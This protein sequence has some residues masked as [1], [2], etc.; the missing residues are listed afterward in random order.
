MKIKNLLLT[1]A[2]AAVV[3]FSCQDPVR[4]PRPDNGSDQGGQDKPVTLEH[5]GTVEDPYSVADA[6][7]FTKAL[8]SDVQSE[9]DVYIKGVVTS[10]KEAFGSFGNVTLYIGD[11]AT[12]TETFYV[13]RV[14]GLGNKKCTD[15]NAVKEGDE[16]VVCGKV[17]NFKGNTPETV[18]GSAF[19]YSINGKSEPVDNPVAGEAKGT[20]TEADPFNVA[21]AIAKCQEAGTTATTEVYYVTGKV[22]AVDESGAV[23]YGNITL[24]LVDEGSTAVFK[25]YRIKSVG[26]AAFTSEGNVQVGDVVV[27]KGQLVNYSNNTPE[28]AQNTGE[29]VSVNGQSPVAKPGISVKAETSINYDILEAEV[30][31]TVNNPVAGQNVTIADVK[32]GGF[33]TVTLEAAAVKVVFA[34]ENTTENAKVVSFTLKYQGASDVT[35]TVTQKV[36]PTG[37]QPSFES[38]L[39]YIKGTNSYDDGKAT[40][41]ETAD[42]VVYKLGTSKAA[43]DCKFTVP[44]GVT[45]IG[46]YAVAWKGLSGIKLTVGDKEVTVDGNDGATST[47][48]YTITLEDPMTV[49]YTVDVTPGDVVVSSSAND[50]AKARV[51]LWGLNP[52]K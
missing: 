3:A 9:N 15:P 26:G 47:S 36:K 52:V 8:G 39:T 19:L 31:F 18:Q 44:S 41:N 1:L 45:K 29:L 5:K 10:I 20:G 43:G 7:A 2:G 25:A 33:A 12:S 32:D 49:Y 4:P 34:A 38:T 21:A 40:I 50:A 48:P 27:V 24:D 6:I 16:V 17:V 35:C 22:T 13:Y 46:F 37:D 42:V 14:L 51:I 30:A 28:T 23:Q 11:T